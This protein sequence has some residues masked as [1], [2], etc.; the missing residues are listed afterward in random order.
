MPIASS[1]LTGIKKSKRDDTP[2]SAA[3]S[4]PIGIKKIIALAKLYRKGYASER[5]KIEGE[6]QPVT[7]KSHD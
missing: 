1:W 2:A 7:K 6:R 3:R 5:K 4:L